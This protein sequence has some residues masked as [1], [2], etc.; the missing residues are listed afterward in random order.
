MPSGQSARRRATK[1]PLKTKTSQT[2]RVMGRSS[3]SPPPKS[4]HKQPNGFEG[5]REWPEWAIN[6]VGASVPLVR[7]CHERFRTSED[8]RAHIEI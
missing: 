8:A 1:I 3:N 5:S 7:Q 4:A 6:D 2:H